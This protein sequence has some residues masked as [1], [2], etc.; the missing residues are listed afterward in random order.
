MMQ[1]LC[2]FCFWR[3]FCL[4]RFDELSPTS[5]CRFAPSVFVPT[6]QNLRASAPDVPR[7]AQ[8]S[9]RRMLEPDL[10]F[11]NEFERVKYFLILDALQRH[12]WRQDYAAK[13]LRLTERA[14]S[15]HI[16]KY[17]LRHPTWRKFKPEQEIA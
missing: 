12:S 4:S 17:H 2:G 6:I 11:E 9:V 15:Y 1:E 8:R 14:M 7:V 10:I 3:D 13:E 16:K 5:T